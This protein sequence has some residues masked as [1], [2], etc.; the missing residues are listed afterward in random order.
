MPETAAFLN[1]PVLL[2]LERK[3][4][5]LLVLTA[6]TVIGGYAFL[7][8][9][10]GVTDQMPFTQEIVLIILGTV[11]TVLITALL[12][13]KQTAVE[14]EKEQNIKFLELKTRTYEELIGRIEDMSLKE[15]ISDRD[16][17][18]MQF[19]THR[20]A[21]F[22]SPAVLEEFRNFLE[23]LKTTTEDRDISDEDDAEA[24]STALA[25][26]TTRIRADLLGETEE[27]EEERYSEEQ[28]NRMILRNSSSAMELH[29]DDETENA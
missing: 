29:P 20:L 19:T 6:I 15:R 11:A 3:Q 2:N 1:R 14:I 12:L 25:R 26:L 5:V 7:R 18:R 21:I 24:I 16:L 13:N 23:V 27:R 4:L 9:A 8:Y 17:I 22:A 28:I 10:Y